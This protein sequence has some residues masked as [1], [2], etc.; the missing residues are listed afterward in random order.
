MLLLP[1]QFL[2]RASLEHNI[3][4]RLCFNFKQGNLLCL[5]EMKN[6]ASNVIFDSWTKARLQYCELFYAFIIKHW[7]WKYFFSKTEK[8]ST[9]ETTVVCH[10]GPKAGQKNLN[11]SIS[12]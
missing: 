10:F 7:R 6:V 4:E 12:R 3:M 5:C 2:N 8:L 1:V 9:P 11:V